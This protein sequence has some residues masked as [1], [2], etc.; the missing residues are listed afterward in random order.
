[1][2][3][4]TSFFPD[5]PAPLSKARSLGSEQLSEPWLDEFERQRGV[6]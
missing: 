1:L 3:I 6:Q 2:I 4:E 5:M